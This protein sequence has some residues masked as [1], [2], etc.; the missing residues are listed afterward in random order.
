MIELNYIDTWNDKK[1]K[2]FFLI[3]YF[4]FS[5]LIMIFLFLDILLA[6]YQLKKMKQLLNLH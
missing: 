1:Q 6:Q 2:L 5:Y 4:S 3:I